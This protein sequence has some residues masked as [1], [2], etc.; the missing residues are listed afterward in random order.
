[1]KIK[2]AGAVTVMNSSS[3]AVSVFVV[4]VRIK[5]QGNVLWA[6]DF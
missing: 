6:L 1:M 2:K 3:F 4:S 5:R